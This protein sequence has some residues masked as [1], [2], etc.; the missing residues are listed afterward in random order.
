MIAVL[1]MAER[2][3]VDRVMASAVGL[4][5]PLE[6]FSAGNRAFLNHL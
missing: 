6:R 4:T 5:N 2:E 1:K 3:I